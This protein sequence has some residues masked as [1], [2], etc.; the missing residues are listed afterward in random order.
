MPL[1]MLLV[2]MLALALNLALA[3]I[4]PRRLL[5]ILPRPSPSASCA[6]SVERPMCTEMGV[7]D[8]HVRVRKDYCFEC[9][10]ARTCSCDG[11]VLYAARRVARS[12]PHGAFRNAA[13]S[14]L[15][16]VA[17]NRSIES[18]G[19][20]EVTTRTPP[21]GPGRADVPRHGRPRR[22]GRHL[23]PHCDSWRRRRLGNW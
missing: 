20:H 2:L 8:D 13:A 14:V 9:A 4:R 10:S 18:R 16:P 12:K 15:L 6:P 3:L 7:A 17:H 23:A 1:I 21:A 22:A 11:M 19:H 5:P